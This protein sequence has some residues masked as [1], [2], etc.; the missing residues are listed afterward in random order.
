MNLHAS[1]KQNWNNDNETE[2]LFSKKKWDTILP[3]AS[4]LASWKISKS[5]TR[6]LLGNWLVPDEEVIK[7]VKKGNA[8]NK[9]LVT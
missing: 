5:S 3:W 1:N 9:A 7:W 4:A 6:G 2:L 8:A